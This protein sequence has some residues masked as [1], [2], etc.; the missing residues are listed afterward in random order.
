MEPRTRN[1]Y[2]A[3]CACKLEL[4]LLYCFH[5]WILQF[6]RFVNG[7][8]LIA[9]MFQVNHVFI[10]ILFNPIQGF[11]HSQIARN[12]EFVSWALNLQMPPVRY[13]SQKSNIRC[14]GSWFLAE[15]VWLE[16]KR[17]GPKYNKCNACIWNVTSSAVR[18][19]TFRDL[20]SIWQ[21]WILS[22]KRYIDSFDSIGYIF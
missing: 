2:I 13:E 20:L 8:T 16:S 19:Q 14:V 7:T 11:L 17:N 6:H 18:N 4:L 1:E 21:W 3:S 10:I 5:N 12:T 22:H 9:I 15:I